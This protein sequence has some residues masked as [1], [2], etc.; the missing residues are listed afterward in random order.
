MKIMILL[1]LAF[2]NTTFASE[3]LFLPASERLN[4]QLIQ[5]LYSV[6]SIGY[7]SGVVVS[8]NKIITAYH[9]VSGCSCPIAGTKLA[10]EKNFKVPSAV[11]D[12]GE[13]IAWRQAKTRNMLFCGLN[14]GASGAV[15]AAEVMARYP[16]YD[17]IVNNF[18]PKEEIAILDFENAHLNLPSAPV[19]Q[20]AVGPD[21]Q[22]TLMGFSGA[23]VRSRQEKLDRVDLL[24]QSRLLLDRLKIIV[25]SAPYERAIPQA[26][27]Y[28]EQEKMRLLAPIDTLPRDSVKSK[29]LLYGSSYI[30]SPQSLVAFWT[31]HLLDNA[32]LSWQMNTS[33][34]YK[35]V[36]TGEL[37]SSI[38]SI[39]TTISSIQNEEKMLYPEADQSLRVSFGKMTRYK[40]TRASFLGLLDT[41]VD[42]VSGNS[43]G[44]LF[45]SFGYL[46]GIASTGPRSTGLSYVKGKGAS[47]VSHYS[48]NDALQTVP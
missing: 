18:F 20:V 5:S 27:E 41:D 9:V 34:C 48:I 46:V 3:G 7:G 35:V 33:L 6:V 23:S 28:F 29:I 15:L 13:V 12:K 8:G 1:I 47:V 43:G 10:C 11:N 36:W 37:D 2:S 40:Y 31:D 25:N 16:S 24:V 42:A 22:L 19:R 39:D 4:A 45:D 38:R 21:D 44:P 26:I 32:C 17:K 14:S 30:L